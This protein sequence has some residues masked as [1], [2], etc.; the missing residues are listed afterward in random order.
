MC[1]SAWGQV[2]SW[3]FPRGF[4]GSGADLEPEA[5]VAGFENVAVMGEAIEQGGCHLGVAEHP[6][7][8]A[9]AQIGGDDGAGALVELAR[10]SCMMVRSLLATSNGG[11]G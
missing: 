2:K 4:G 9:E 1:F 7:P 10:S 11:T 3:L 8:L 6:G 5:V